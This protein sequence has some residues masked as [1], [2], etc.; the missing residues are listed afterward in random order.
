[1]ARDATI[2]VTGRFFGGSERS[3]GSGRARWFWV[4]DR[5][6]VFQAVHVDDIHVASNSPRVN[7]GN[8]HPGTCFV[9]ASV[10]TLSHEAASL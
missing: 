10:G 4:A 7:Q 1:M 8:E 3:P 6:V 5:R 2:A 9:L